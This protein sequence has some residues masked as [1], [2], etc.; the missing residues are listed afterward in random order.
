MEA[1][2]LAAGKGTRMRSEK[3]KVLHE[4]FDRPLLEYVLRTVEGAGVKCPAV[5]IGS[6]AEQVCSFLEKR[7]KK[8]S[9]VLQKEQRGTG[10]AVMQAEKLYRGRKGSL[11]IWPGD[12]PL[13][14]TETLAAFIKAHQ[15]A[16]AK[17]S[18][19]S[20]LRIEPKGYGRILRMGGSFYAIREELDATESERRIQEVNTGVYLFDVEALFASLKKIKPSNAKQE[21][22]LTD[23]IEVLYQ[24][25]ERI[26]AFP[27]ALQDEGQGINSRIDL[28][29][30]FTVMNKREIQKHQESGV[31]IISPETTF[32]APGVKLGQDT[33]IY[34][35]T[36]IEENVKIGRDCKIGP[37]AKIR[38]G[39]D[40][41][42]ECVIGSF[43]EVSRS[44]IGKKVMMKHLA[45]LGDAV[46]G[47]E[48]NIGCGA[49][50][51]NFDGKKK[52]QTKIGKKVLVGS[53]T[54]FVAPVWI[55]DEAR[56]GAGSVVTAKT[57][58]EKRGV[59]AGVPAK[60]VEKR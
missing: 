16:K 59:I 60:P 33:V 53:N 41:G 50:T 31:T 35:C 40:I 11:L 10:H 43:V 20:C 52:H 13:L 30:A 38:Q 21:L 18:V 26:E 54:V 28:A 34:P 48:T 6:G 56:T 25:N 44:K 17:V 39:A 57:K 36:Y 12:M 4:I 15:E 19:L 23:V 22:Y 32:I 47:D 3:P 55:G 46:V 45:Y 5:V 7:G 27:F 14:K 2:I 51:A 58:V 29:Q 42:D 9:T 1:L 37:F 8:F 24:K 49:I